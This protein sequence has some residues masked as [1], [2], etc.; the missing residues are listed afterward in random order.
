[1][2]HEESKSDGK[3]CSFECMTGTDRDSN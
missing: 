3:Q 2:P 1:M